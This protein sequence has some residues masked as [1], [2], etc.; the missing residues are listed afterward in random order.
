MR[1]VLLAVGSQWRVNPVQIDRVNQYFAIVGPRNWKLSKI[2]RTQ[3]CG[4][5]PADRSGS[6]CE[7]VHGF[8]L[9]LQ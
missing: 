9:L 7:G 6:C 8:Q 1:L 3:D 2:D 4:F 5:V